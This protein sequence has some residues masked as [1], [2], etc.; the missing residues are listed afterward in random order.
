HDLR[1]RNFCLPDSSDSPASDSKVSG[2]TGACHHGWLIFVFLVETGLC[3]VG[4]AGLELLTSG[5]PPASASQSA[6]ITEVSC[7]TWPSLLYADLYLEYSVMQ[8]YMRKWG[9]SLQTQVLFD[10]HFSHLADI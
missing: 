10:H 6:G 4:L 7:C 3:H 9:L 1:S 8:K 5:D 2:I